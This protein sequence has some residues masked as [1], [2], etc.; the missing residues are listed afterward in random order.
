MEVNHH[1][2]S[3][4]DLHQEIEQLRE[5]NKKLLLFHSSKQEIQRSYDELLLKLNAESETYTHTILD[6][7]GDS[8]FV[9][10]DKSRLLLVNNAF[11]EMF[12][13]SR[14]DVIGKTLAEDVAVDEKESFLQ[15]DK[16]VLESG[17]EN[18][19]EETLTL[20][21]GE[22][23]VI[24]TRKSR[25]IDASGEKY[26]IGAI[27]DIT[28]S[29][30]AEKALLRSE[31]ELRELNITKDKLFA[32]IGHDLRSPFNNILTL[33]NLIEDAIEDNKI[34]LLEEYV[35]LIKTT[36]NSTLGLLE[37]L[38]T[39]FNSQKEKVNLERE[40]LDIKCLIEEV[41]EFIEHLAKIKN[42]SVQEPILDAM[43]VYSDEKM[44]KT[45]LRNLLS[46]AVK[47]TK[48]GG[49]IH[50]SV[51][52]QMETL[53]FK[54]SDTG[55]GM[56]E[57]KCKVLFASDTNK[58]SRGTA[59]EMGSGFGLVL[60]KEF[61]EKLGGKIWVESEMGKGSDFKFTLPLV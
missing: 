22:Q 49:R 58:S 25:F 27:R 56:S 17:V 15:I 45:I 24:S 46:N 32:I 52:K 31:S 59:N 44:L 5:Q 1:N 8:V 40:K 42:I 41:Q 29:K 34:S 37:N 20:K 55:V 47:F 19:N 10:D 23:L 61:V 7:M 16:V 35:S 18:I 39:W 14:N 26:I 33:S 51:T 60:C 2:K 21:G 11:C 9:K 38:L 36:S 13:M 50:V 57:N 48:S 53:E 28:T 12:G 43:E 3:V 54:V 4:Q 30:N 6:N